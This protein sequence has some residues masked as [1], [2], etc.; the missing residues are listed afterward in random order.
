MPRYID[1]GCKEDIH[2]LRAHLNGGIPKRDI[3][4]LQIYWNIFHSTRQALFGQNTISDYSIALLPIDQV[5]S[6]ILDSTEYE[7]Y[8]KKVKATMRCLKEKY[9]PYLKSLNKSCNP[10]M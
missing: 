8:T 9:E 5:K 10:K 4:Q 3:D 1:N 7:A 2:D 6:T